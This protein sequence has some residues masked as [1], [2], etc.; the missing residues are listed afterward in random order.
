MAKITK[1][2]RENIENRIYK[3]MDLLDKSKANSE[4]YKELFASMDDDKFYKFV[5]KKYPYRFHI[6]Q[7][8]N[9]TM[10]D[11]KKACDFLGVPLMERVSLGYLYENKDGT[12][13]YS[14][15]SYV[16]YL[17]IKRMV[18][19]NIKKLKHGVDVDKRDMRSGR[20]NSDDKGGQTSFREMESLSAL[21]LMDTLDEMSRIR[22]D[23][24]NAKSLANSII[25]TTGQLKLSEVPVEKDDS[26]GKNYFNV[27][28][29]GCHLNS[30]LIN[31]GLYTQYTIKNKKKRISREVE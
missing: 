25:S 18:Q 30:N 11:I 5:S 13:I 17:P 15:P 14:Q 21:G 6:N 22:A 26:L 4:Y 12:P 1:K 10:T 16:I 20:L 9:P 3:V 31:E 19:M 8:I 27:Y 23:A 2:Q 29:L 28:L 24:M 7:D